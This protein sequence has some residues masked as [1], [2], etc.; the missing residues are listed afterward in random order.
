MIIVNVSVV[1][2][3]L[4]TDI[5]DLVIV[6]TDEGIRGWGEITG[7][8]CI[9]GVAA[10]LDS[11]KDYLIGKNPAHRYECLQLFHQWR[12]PKISDLRTYSSALSGLDQALW[13]LYAKHLGIPLYQLYG[14]AGVQSIPLYANLNKALRGDRRESLL[15][16]HGKEAVELGFE[17][18]KCT[19]FDEITPENSTLEFD[20]SIKKMDALVSAVDISHVAIDCHQRFNRFSLSQMLTRVLDRYG[21][22]YWVEDTIA[23]NDYTVQEQISGSFPMFRFAA[24][25]DAVSIYQIEKTVRSH[26]YDVIMPDVKYIGGPSVVLP[27]IGYVEGIGKQLSLH[28]PNGLVATAH[29][30]HLSAISRQKI[31]MEFPFMAV[32]DRASL[33][34]PSEIIRDGSY[35][36]T[37]SPGIGVEI[38][39]EALM[40]YGKTI[41]CGSWERIGV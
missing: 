14:A 38:S 35:Y 41:T 29:S 10:I 1:R 27:L 21:I 34:F 32:P 5:W 36:F 4:K 22:P 33:A 20:N 13:D 30:A 18:V 28:N 19:P 17:I 8:L 40:E 31:P 25:E 39:K 3:T 2:M 11:M 37:E 24:G 6:D 16:E 23:I 12:Y 15:A 9:E 7:S 26:G